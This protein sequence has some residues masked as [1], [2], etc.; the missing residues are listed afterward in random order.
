MVHVYASPDEMQA[1][2]EQLFEP[3]SQEQLDKV[4]VGLVESGQLQAGQA[5]VGTVSAEQLA[6]LCRRVDHVEVA[7]SVAHEDDPELHR[8]LM[9]MQ[10]ARGPQGTSDPQSRPHRRPNGSWSTARP[11][12]GGRPSGA[13]S[14][15]RQPRGPAPPDDRVLSTVAPNPKKPGSKAH[16]VYA[17][18]VQGQ[19]VREFVAA[20]VATGKPEKEALDNLKY[21][22]SRGFVQ[23]GAQETT[24][25]VQS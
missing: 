17:C 13:P 1:K 14:A 18:Y 3:L 6:E 25:A 20:V 9:R 2:Y 21:D 7:L 8:L 12:A 23:L 4:Y 11:S 5:A 19:T 24:N 16:S 15:P 22:I 10:I